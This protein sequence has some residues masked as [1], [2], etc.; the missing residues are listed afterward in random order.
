MNEAP[1]II[2]SPP[3]SSHKD[4]RTGLILFGILEIL[5]G[6]LC[7]LMTGFMVLGQMMLARTSDVPMHIQTLIPA[8][9]SYVVLA[10]TFVW[11]SLRA[12]SLDR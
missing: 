9:M 7:L 11:L 1:P 12:A 4:R 3:A 2:P 8:L 6:A 5:L 10:A